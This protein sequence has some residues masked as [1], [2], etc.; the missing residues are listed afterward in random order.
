MKKS[1]LY[2]FLTF[3]AI[4]LSAQHRADRQQ[5]SDPASSSMILMGDPQGYVKY[6]LNQSVI[7]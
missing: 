7:L 1:I 2:I 6:D 4:S 5:L 3:I